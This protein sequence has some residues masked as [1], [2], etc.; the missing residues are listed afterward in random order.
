MYTWEAAA[1]VK[2]AG[3][4]KF[5]NIRGRELIAKTVRALHFVNIRGSDISAKNV[6]VLACVNTVKKQTSVW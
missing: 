1:C 5:V 6:R 2:N 4:V 3:A